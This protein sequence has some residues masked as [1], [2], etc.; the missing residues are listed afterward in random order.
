M[1]L[2]RLV[3]MFKSYICLLLKSTFVKKDYFTF[4][5][6]ARENFLHFDFTQCWESN[7]TINCG[8]I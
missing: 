1:V 2:L 6:L 3:F 7:E 8:E 4:F 5:K